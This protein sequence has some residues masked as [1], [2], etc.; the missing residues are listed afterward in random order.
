M[1]GLAPRGVGG[2]GVLL[3]LFGFQR[4][5]VLVCVLLRL[6]LACGV[7]FGGLCV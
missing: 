2:L 4:A 1:L 7:V 5:R 6:V 3:H